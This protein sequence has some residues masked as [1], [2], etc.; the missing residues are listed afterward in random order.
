MREYLNATPPA[1]G[2][3][4]VYY[5]GEVEHLK[6]QERRRTGI[7]LEEG[8][9]ARLQALVREYGLEGQVGQP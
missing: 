7:T 6:A 1:T 5:P 3:D 9:W 8:T 4:R 2:F